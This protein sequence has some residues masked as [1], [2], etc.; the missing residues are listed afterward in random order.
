[1]WQLN[2]FTILSTPLRVYPTESQLGKTARPEKKPFH[3][4]RVCTRNLGGR[5]SSFT[6]NRAPTV[7]V[8]AWPRPFG[9]LA[10]GYNRI[11]SH[12]LPVLRFYT[13]GVQLVPLPFQGLLFKCF[14]TSE[15]QDKTWVCGNCMESVV[16]IYGQY[17]ADYVLIRSRRFLE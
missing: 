10:N 4:R 13:K 5:H 16:K 1:M 14:G 2:Q 8:I 12:P 15:C 17:C 3:S 7:S 6:L 11:D 9:H